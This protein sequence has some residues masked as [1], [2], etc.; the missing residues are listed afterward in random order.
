MSVYLGK[1]RN[2]ANADVTF[3]HLTLLQ[4]V[5]KADRVGHDVLWTITLAHGSF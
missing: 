1:Q 2:L 4:L 5:W 3:I